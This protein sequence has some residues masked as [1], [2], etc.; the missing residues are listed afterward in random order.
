MR[1][2][3]L[4]I[5][6]L[7]CFAQSP[8]D[9]E[10]S[11]WKQQ[12]E[13]VTIIRDNWG[14]PHIYGK[15]DADAVFGLMY[16]Q[17]EENFQRVEEN[18][19]EMMGRLSELYGKSKLY[20]DLEMRLI[21]DSSA[22]I[23]DY[24]KSPAWFKKLLDASADG[25]NFF[26]Y[27][28]PEV[29]PALLTRF[30]P[31]FA[32]LR[33][34]GSISATQTG[35]LTTKDMVNL[36]G[37]DATTS[38]IQVPKH[39]YENDPTGSNGFAIAPS[40]TASKH[41]IL[42]I[43]PHVTFYFRTE[44]QMVSEEG[45][46]VYGAVTWSN[47]FVY[48]GFNEHCGWMHTSSYADVA[49]LFTEKIDKKGDSYFS[50]YDGK[51]LPVKTRNITIAYTENDIKQQQ[52]FTTYTTV[53]GPVMG[54]RDGQWLSLREN[55]RSLDALMQ[56]WL[57]TKA[58][59][60]EDFKKIMNLRANNSNNTVF[61]DDKGNIAYWHGNF[62]PKRNPLYDY[63]LP[64][65]G[66]ISAT[67]WKGLHTLDE[68]V[69]LYNPS[70]GWIENCNSTPYTAAGS[71]SPKAK[72]YPAYMAPDGQ[73]YRAMNAIRLLSAAQ[74]LTPDQVIKEIGYSHYLSAFDELLPPLF[75]AFD[76]LPANDSMRI[77]LSEAIG[78]I[79]NWDKNSSATSV[80]STL[81]IE[82]AYRM[83]QKASPI[84]NPYNVSDMKGQVAS[85]ISNTSPAQKLL[86]LAQT[87]DD[88]QSR[89]ST[90]KIAWGEVNRYQR[91][92]D[93]SFDDRKYSFPV[94]LAAGTWGSI[95]SF[96]TRRFENTN[97][98]F[99][100]SGNSFIACVE[101]GK[102]VKAKSVITGGQSFDP[103]SP[104]FTDQAERYIDGNFKDVLFYKEDV[105]QH[106]EKQYHPGE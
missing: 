75:K 104:H 4:L 106:V 34:D 21:Y 95:P 29:K 50:L 31:W 16:A 74:N 41:A 6:P 26:L 13:R 103:L 55:N 37:K 18:T 76:K 2:L 25:V 70:S 65:D 64:V 91:T 33:T 105:L 90:W 97:K 68:I 5:L 10:I 57:R 80:A 99:G 72:D 3:L 24:K 30:E 84:K 44:V 9:A 36:Y 48:Q 53:H 42:Y 43:N 81:A 7:Y 98:R 14:V 45:L 52:N 69:H 71:S 32:L 67:D 56:S 12:A 66:S 100:L 17:C 35:G 79:R 59:G 73:N 94:G 28:H 61:A 40:K 83:G 77:R 22:A 85:M 89:F 19:L 20:D 63:S 1:F 87:L 93:G 47:F 101:F 23:N 78:L 102:K 15:T 54:S 49:D 39:F 46:N 8:G 60:F 88:L 11:C 96:A 27:K 38:Y 58:K 51:L 62:M 82:W 92:T 86:L